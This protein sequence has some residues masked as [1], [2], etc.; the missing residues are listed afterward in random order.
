[1][2][3]ARV[4]VLIVALV[5]GGTA[6]SLIGIG[7]DKEPARA[8]VVQLPAI[9]ARI[10]TGNINININSNSNSSS[11]DREADIHTVRFGVSANT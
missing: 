5:A 1:M 2:K 7:A 3:A 8:L 11:S 9:D 6:A 4:L 10:V